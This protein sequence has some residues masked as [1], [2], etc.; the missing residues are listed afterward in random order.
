[1]VLK[2]IETVLMGR[3]GLSPS[4]NR[5]YKEG[6]NQNEAPKVLFKTVQGLR[7]AGVIRLNSLR[8]LNAL[9][10]E[11]YDLLAAWGGQGEFS[12]GGFRG[13]IPLVNFVSPSS[14]ID[15]STWEGGNIV[16]DV[17]DSDGTIFNV[18][19]LIDGEP[20]A[21]AN[22]A[23]Y[24]FT[25]LTTIIQNLS[26]EVHYLQVIATDNDGNTNF[27]RL[28][29]I[30]GD[31]PPAVEEEVREESSQI[32]VFPNPTHN[33]ELTIEMTQEST[34]RVRIYDFIGRLVDNFIFE[35]IKYQYINR[36]LADGIYILEIQNGEDILIKEKLL[37]R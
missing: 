16:L 10:T 33:R 35:G 18:K 12:D 28:P 8:N 21:M 9:S 29:I 20:V 26:H 31:P 14:G 11:M 17:T 19:V 6:M 15:V 3:K 5:V 1:M 24:T 13:D 22:E 4:K 30:G 25:D 7:K 23:P 36:N 37:I 34:Y 2:K 32:R 27:T